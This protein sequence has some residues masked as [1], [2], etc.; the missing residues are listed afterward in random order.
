MKK[1][2]IVLGLAAVAAAPVAFAGAQCTPAQICKPS[3]SDLIDGTPYTI[4]GLVGPNTSVH[5]VLPK[6]LGNKKNECNV[7][8]PTNS[9]TP[10]PKLKWFITSGKNSEVKYDAIST[11]AD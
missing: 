4:S 5:I 8:M 7:Y 11:T 6:G 3:L 2:L 10:I 9:S 1:Y